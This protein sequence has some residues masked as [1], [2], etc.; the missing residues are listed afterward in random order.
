MFHLASDSVSVETR[1]HI[2]TVD[3]NLLSYFPSLTTYHV[4][5]V[6]VAKGFKRVVI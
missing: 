1:L 5:F 3:V 6:T 4:S 2:T